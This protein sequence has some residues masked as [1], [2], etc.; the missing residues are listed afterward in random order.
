[1]NKKIKQTKQEFIGFLKD[2]KVI[3]LSIAVIIGG[4]A[5]DLVNSIVSNLIM[6]II[7][8]LTP[9]GYW[10]QIKFKIGNSEFGLGSFLGSLVDFIVIALLVFFVTKKIL[11][12]DK[13]GK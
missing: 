3:S 2:Q 6:P 10:R 13:A 11:K 9:D 1:M 4:A 8:I 7:G 5:K 12:I